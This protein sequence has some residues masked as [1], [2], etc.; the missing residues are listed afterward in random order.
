MTAYVKSIDG[1][2]VKDE[3]A[4]NQIATLTGTVNQ[5]NGKI[6]EQTNKINANTEEI[7]ELKAL[8]HLQVKYDAT[9]EA[10]TF[11]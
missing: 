2:M 3:E 11:E 9:N 1:Y 8:S 4:R 6:N 5:Q 10:I 7:N